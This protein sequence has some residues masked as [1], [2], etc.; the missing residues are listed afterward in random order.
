MARRRVSLAEARRIAIAAQG[1]AK[2]RPQRAIT[3]RDIRAVIRRLGLIQLDFVNVLIPAHYQPVFSRV[4]PY[5][6]SL[7]DKTVYRGRQFTEQWPHEACII[8]VETW[9]LLRF[10]MDEHRCRPRGFETFLQANAEYAQIALNTVR[11]N[12]P[13]AAA[14]LP[15]PD[16]HGRRLDQ[17]WFGTLPRAVLEYHFAKGALTVVAR[18]PDMARVFDLAE[19]W[20]PATLHSQRIERAEAHRQLLDRAAQACGIATLA[21]LADY[22]RLSPA[23]CRPRL[24][25]LVSSGRVR[26]VE[27]EGW[28]EPAYLHED[29]VLPRS[30]DARALLSPFDPLIFYRP[31]VARLFHFNYR[32]EI[33]TPEAQRK[34][35]YYVLPFLLGDTLVARFDLKADRAGSRLLVRA[36]HIEPGADPRFTAEAALLEI[37]AWAAWLGLT[38]IV[39][40]RKGNLAAALRQARQ[41]RKSPH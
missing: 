26:T 38:S 36:S 30:I 33:Y 4:G 5:P 31:R 35:G 28:R 16:G 32:I 21:D 29:A 9:P 10:R 8:P 17:A 40:E 34:F 11:D 27:V 14:A 22:Y 7:F 13:I 39:M 18:K 6:R 20:I 19:R 1:F 2:A 25:D 12:G 15:D 41:R 37:E 24:D 3:G 23:D